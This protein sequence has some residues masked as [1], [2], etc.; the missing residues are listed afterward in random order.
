MVN[1][2]PLN[3]IR[4]AW[5]FFKRKLRGIAAAILKKIDPSTRSWI[6]FLTCPNSMQNTQAL[7][8][9]IRETPVTFADAIQLLFPFWLLDPTA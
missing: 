5:R 2:I 8:A 7:Q 9:I 6:N 3:K 1:R 4:V